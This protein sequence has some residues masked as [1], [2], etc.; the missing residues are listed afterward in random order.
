MCKCLHSLCR[1]V[2]AAERT[3]RYYFFLPHF[4]SFVFFL[5]RFKSEHINAHIR[6]YFIKTANCEYAFGWHRI[7]SHHA[8]MNESRWNDNFRIIFFRV[9]F[10]FFFSFA[11]YRKCKN[12]KQYSIIKWLYTCWPQQRTEDLGTGTFNFMSLCIYVSV[13]LSLFF[14]PFSFFA[15]RVHCP[16]A[17]VCRFGN[18]LLIQYLTRVVVMQCTLQIIIIIAQPHRWY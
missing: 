16:A 13:S 1:N 2:V 14:S 15:V 4:V 5:G 17:W 3:I 18:L 8:C 12:A 10:L 9:F 11:R 6:F 7:T